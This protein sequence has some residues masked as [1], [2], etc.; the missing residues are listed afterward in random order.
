[1]LDIHIGGRQATFCQS[2]AIPAT[3]VQPTIGV[4][5]EPGDRGA[6]Y[7]SQP[8]RVPI[9]AGKAEPGVSDCSLCKSSQMTI[10][11]ELVSR[12]TVSHTAC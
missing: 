1:M 10:R 12:L 11:S 8:S 7:Y 4:I 5:L 9:V 2:Y 3:A 6:L